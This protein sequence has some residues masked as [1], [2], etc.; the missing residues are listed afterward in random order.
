MVLGDNIFNGH[1]FS[2]L[3]S[4]SIANVEDK[5]MATVFGYYMS[6]AKRYGVVELTA[7]PMYSLLK[8]NLKIQKAITLWL[9]C[10]F[11]PTR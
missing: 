4:K 6:D 7:K 9:V 11:T 3:L 8:R 1:G 5:K 2:D 10:I